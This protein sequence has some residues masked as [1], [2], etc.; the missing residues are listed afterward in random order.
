LRESLE[1]A[2]E[3]A[4]PNGTL[5]IAKA[6]DP[7]SEDISLVPPD[8]AKNCGAVARLYVAKADGWSRDNWWSDYF[9]KNALHF[10]DR[11]LFCP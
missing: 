3:Y 5:G 8:Y 1:N 6:D 2:K 4:Y 10:R 9:D 7:K 11:T